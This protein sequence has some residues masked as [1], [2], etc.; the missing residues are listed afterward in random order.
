MQGRITIFAGGIVTVGLMLAALW[1]WQHAEQ[2]VA[3]W[4]RPGVAAWSVRS[5]AIGLAAGAQIV[6]LVFVVGRIY[7]RDLVNE[8]LQL[9]AG[10][11]CTL[12]LVSAIALGLASR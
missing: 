1:G 6:C 4:S 9:I 7:R 8:A 5:L 2:V 12:A 3:G 11:L 10:L